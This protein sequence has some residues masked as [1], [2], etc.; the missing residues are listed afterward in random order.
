MNHIGSM[1][2]GKWVLVLLL[3]TTFTSPQLSAAGN[4]PDPSANQPQKRPSGINIG[5]TRFFIGAHAGMNF[6]NAASDLF[7]VVTRDLTLQ[8]SDFQAPLF[9]FDFGVTFQSHFAAVFAIEYSKASPVS[10]FRHYVDENGNSIVQNNSF[11]QL[12]ITGTLRYYPLKT[13]ESVGSYVWMPVRFNPYIA[14]GGGLMRYDFR[15]SGSFVDNSTLNIFDHVFESDGFG[16]AGHLAGGFDINFSKRLFANIEA[17]YVFSHKHLSQDFTRF[18]PID[19]WGLRMSGGF[20]V[21][22]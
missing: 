16:P 9:S 2:V 20:G 3:L 7:S 18:N 14:A 17:R 22:F 21:R 11:S 6:P 10:E 4:D 13:G 19:L 8:K 12:P 1:R 5:K 15:Q